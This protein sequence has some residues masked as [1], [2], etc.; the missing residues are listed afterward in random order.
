MPWL[1]E[2]DIFIPIECNTRYLCEFVTMGGRMSQIDPGAR[3]ADAGQSQGPKAD[4]EDPKADRFGMILFLSGL[5]AA[6]SLASLPF[7]VVY[8]ASRQAAYTDVLFPLLLV[9]GVVALVLVVAVLVGLFKRMGLT[10]PAHPLGLPNGSISAIIALMLI[11][12]FAMLSV[13]VQVNLAPD[14]RQISELTP[15]QVDQLPGAE[16]LARS[17]AAGRCTISRRVEKTSAQVDIG[18]Q[19]VT[20]VSTLVVAISAFYFGSVQSNGGGSRLRQREP[21]AA[22]NREI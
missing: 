17:C 10:N 18:K 9:A 6:A 2:F 8:L 7:S 16:I 1:R 12:V 5:F 13:L 20:T 19:L 15:A 21:D 11:L 14:E 22:R 4:R 3:P